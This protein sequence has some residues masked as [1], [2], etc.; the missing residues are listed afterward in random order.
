MMH[1]LRYVQ[2]VV[3]VRSSST[4]TRG[5]AEDQDGVDRSGKDVVG[6]SKAP[7]GVPDRLAVA[8]G[9]AVAPPVAA[10]GRRV[11]GGP[12]AAEPAHCWLL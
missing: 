6:T 2:L 7:S 10:E 5:G 12:F 9:V 4:P 1:G 11:S 8:D 3:I